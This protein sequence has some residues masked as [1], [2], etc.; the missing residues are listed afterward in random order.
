MNLKRW[1]S[2]FNYAQGMFAA[3]KIDQGKNGE[4]HFKN[5]P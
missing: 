4:T 2:L 1:V 3:T 5:N